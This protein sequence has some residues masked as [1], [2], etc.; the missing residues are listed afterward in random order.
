MRYFLQLSYRGTAYAG[1]QSQPNAVTVQS[2]LEDRLQRMMQHSIELVGCGRTDAGVHASDFYAHFDYPHSFDAE[3][4]RYRLNNFLPNDIAV[5]HF[6]PVSADAH[7][8]F[9]ATQRS[10]T[11]Y[12][13]FEKNPFHYEQ[14][15][16]YQKAKKL[17]IDDLNRFGQM[18]LSYESFF[19]FCK[20]HSDVKTHRCQLTKCYWTANPTGLVF[21]ISADRF[22][23]GMVRLIVGASLLYAEGKFPLSTFEDALLHQARLPQSWSVPAQG[24]FLSQIQYPYLPSLR[25]D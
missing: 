2:I 4:I 15:F 10:Y 22:L 14:S 25:N 24:L 17:N 1:W 12:L 13:H 18:L 16:Y 23:R 6:H 3:D 5:H 7:A 8:R 20:L 19:P 21:H 9:D 11:Y